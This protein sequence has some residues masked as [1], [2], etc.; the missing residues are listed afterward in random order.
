MANG[1]GS[2]TMDPCQ[3]IAVVTRQEFGVLANGEIFGSACR[4]LNYKAVDV[5]MYCFQLRHDRHF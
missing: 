2:L 5:W 1:A 3:E 4:L